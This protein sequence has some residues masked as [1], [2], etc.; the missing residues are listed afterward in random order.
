MP[1]HLA[2]WIHRDGLTHLKIKLNGDDLKWDV[3]RVVKVNAI[4]EEAQRQR[5]VT[6]WWYSLDFNERCKDVRYLND[7][8]LLASLGMS[9]EAQWEVDFHLQ[10]KER[11]YEDAVLAA[12]DITF[13]KLEVG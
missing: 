5:G 8:I 9:T 3:D 4:A 10:L 1:E 2:E 12:H 7:F 11:D 6:E 13:A